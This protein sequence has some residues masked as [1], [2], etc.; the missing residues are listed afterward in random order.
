M[1]KQFQRTAYK[2]SI[3]ALVTLSIA[4]A[5]NPV[6]SRS[7]PNRQHN[8]IL[9]IGDG[10]GWEMARAAAIQNSI[11]KGKSGKTL[12]DF[13][14]RGRGSGLNMQTLAEYALSTT[15]GTTIADS[16]GKYSGNNSALDGTHKLTGASPVRPNFKFDPNFNP[17]QAGK[18][19]PDSTAPKVGNLV[20]YDPIKG[21]VNPWTPGIDREYIKA[22]YPDSANTAT[23]LYTGVKSYNNA[24]AVDIYERPLTTILKTAA[25]L[26]KSTG[27]VTSVPIDH[28]TPGAAAANVNRRTKYDLNAPDATPLD[29]ILQQELRIYQPTVLLGG[30]HPLSNIKKPLPTGVEPDHTYISETTYR[31]LTTHPDRNI[32]KYTF[33]ERGANAAKTLAQ[34][35]AKID[36]NRG[37]RLLGV[38][39]AR[40]Q[41]GNIPV[42]SANRDYG[43]TGFDLFKVHSTR[44]LKPDTERPLAQGETN[45][46]F[47]QRESNENP[48]LNDLTTAALTVLNKDPD[49]FWL[50]IEGGDIDWSA[51]DN[52]LDNL[53]G[54]VLDFDRSVGTV[55]KWIENHGGW[56]RNQ[57]IV[58]ADHDHYFTLNDDFPTKLRQQG[59]KSLTAA[60]IAMDAGHYWGSQ[61]VVAKDVMGKELPETG[62]YGWG[63]HSNRPVPVYYQGFASD[64]LT[65]SIGQGFKLYDN[66]IPG[67]PGLTDQ[68]HIYQT[69]LAAV[70]TLVSQSRSR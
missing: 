23:T 15:Y 20:G 49:G 45:A 44:G 66:D 28:A 32:Y 17:G 8:T 38:Y 22:S 2:W 19:S 16:N 7:V 34:T 68:I 14:V 62:K 12:K 52:N 33:R 35:A 36:P 11:D 64:V 3:L 42:S 63:N 67:I 4:V 5:I 59:A 65:K 13:Y 46:K 61:P 70:K 37:Q 9:M 58:T 27:L 40:G 56:N 1:L 41:N 57:L 30:G 10:M 50:M 47:I 55:I 69:Q 24:I 53:I 60:N 21:G 25:S 31:E 51:H 6:L 29:N 39:G 48:T 43:T 26:G 18:N 54:T